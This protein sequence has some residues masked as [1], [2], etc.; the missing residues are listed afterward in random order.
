MAVSPATETKLRAAMQ[1]LLDGAPLRTDGALTKE[2]LAREAEVSHATVHRAHEIL[3]EWDARVCRP[4]LR[5]TGEVRRDERI[6][7]LAAAL[8]AEKQK[9]TELHGKFDALASVT[10]NL[11]NENLA[12]RRK[13]DKQTRIASLDT[14][15]PSSGTFTCS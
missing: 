6:E 11:N 12:M 5:S 14:P 1:R 9:V 15:D 3:T 7:Q 4:V 8:R 10:A 13:L 2:N